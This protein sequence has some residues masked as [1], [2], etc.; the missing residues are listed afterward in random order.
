MSI[1][2]NEEDIRLSGRTS[3]GVR[4]ILLSKGD[5]VVSMEAE[6]D[7]KTV[8]FV[9]ENGIGKR[10]KFEDFSLQGRG[11]KGARGY[12]VTDKTG[13]I[14]ST[15]AVNE[16]EEVMLIT[17]EGIII[18]TPVTSI[19]VLGKTTS[20]VK[21]MALSKE[22]EAKIA[23]FTVVDSEEEIEEEELKG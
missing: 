3:I 17:T 5:C 22:G 19:P 15:E 7:D 11:G 1:F 18:R 2:F 23:S 14:V 10:S 12:K 8:L 9:A 6:T 20:G 4:G 21:L 13:E 16:E